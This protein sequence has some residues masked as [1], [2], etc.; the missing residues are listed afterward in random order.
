VNKKD[1][2]YNEKHEFAIFV[3]QL[4]LKLQSR[5]VGEKLLLVDEAFVH[6]I[7]HV[8]RIK[9]GDTCII[10]DQKIY[11]SVEIVEFSG[12]K[13]VTL[14]LRTITCASQLFP[15]IVFLLPLLKRDDYEA[16]IYALTELGVNTIQPIFTQKSI[17]SWQ[18]KDQERIQR[19]IIAAAEQSK[20]FAYPLI[21]QPIPLTQA[22]DI[23][24]REPQKIFFDALGDSLISVMDKI[25]QVSAEKIILLIGPEGDLTAEEK[26]MVSEHKFLF[27]ALTP[28]VIRAFQAASLGAGLVRSLIR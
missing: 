11:S 2:A 27:S 26:F 18:I 23:Y 22:L 24:H 10:F 5:G 13:S 9:M 25:R 7:T 20:N 3:P 17:R 21:N 16:A 19:I 1:T 15:T 4:S 12:K 6:R 14:L 8:L 28:T